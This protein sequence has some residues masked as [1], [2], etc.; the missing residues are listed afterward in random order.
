MEV[1]RKGKTVKLTAKVGAMKNDDKVASV[2]PD[3]KAAK[4]ATQV[5]GMSVVS[6]DADTLKELKIKGGVLVESAEGAA[7]AAGITEGDIVV[8]VNDTDVTSPEQFAKVVAGL[9]KARPVGLM[10]RR[11][12]QTQWVAVK[13]AK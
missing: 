1:W 9:D 2:K 4:A 12:Q 10:I 7:S 11:G 6:V 13:P 3:A 5:L 8:V